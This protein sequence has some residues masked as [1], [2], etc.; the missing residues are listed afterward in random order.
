MIS[1]ISDL[2]RMAI[3]RDNS[4]WLQRVAE[5][6]LKI[7]GVDTTGGRQSVPF[8]GGVDS[9]PPYFPGQEMQQVICKLPCPPLTGDYVLTS[10][11]GKQVWEAI[12][13]CP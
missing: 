6:T 12:E 11:D 8:E 9:N 1:E 13:D 4:A 5:T 7:P 2:V 3:E 10:T